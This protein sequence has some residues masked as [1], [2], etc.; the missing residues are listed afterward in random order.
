MKTTQ[1]LTARQLRELEAEL[2]AERARLERALSAEERDGESPSEDVGLGGGSRS[3]L[4]VASP[5]RARARY[6]L[7]VGAL[8]RL[9]AGNYGVCTGCGQPIP[10]GRLIVMPEVKHCVT[11]PPRG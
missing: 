4:G 10:Y 2:V 11:C 3:T 9:A 6:D 5:S 7:V 1:P 8:H